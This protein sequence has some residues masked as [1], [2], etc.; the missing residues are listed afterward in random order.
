MHSPAFY[1]IVNH[2]PDCIELSWH[3]AS[4]ERVRFYEERGCRKGNAVIAS[5]TEQS[6]VIIIVSENRQFLQT[7]ANLPIKIMSAAEAKSRL[8]SAS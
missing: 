4:L 7:L 8:E 2:Y 3:P 6:G 1:D 5:H